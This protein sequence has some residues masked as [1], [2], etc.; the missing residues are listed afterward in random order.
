MRKFFAFLLRLF[1]WSIKVSV[2]IPT[3]CVLCVA[4]HTSNW[5]FLIGISFYKSIGGNPHF[6]MKKDWFF[7]PMGNILRSIGGIPV[8]RSK[9]TSLS[10][11]MAE[12]FHTEE[13][14]QLA[15]APEGSRKKTSHWKTGFYYIAL[16]ANVPI[17]LAYIDYQK[18]EVGVNKIFRPTGDVDSDMAEIKDYYKNVK[19]KHP[20]KFTI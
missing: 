6:L 7:F 3:K 8:D 12:M 10:D 14:F 18:K 9:K 17:T 11:Q 15:V 16:K 4:P 20:E 1:G 2:E 13:N 5:D 19:G